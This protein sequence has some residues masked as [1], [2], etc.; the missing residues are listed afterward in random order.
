MR[1]IHHS[2]IEASNLLITRATHVCTV[3]VWKHAIAIAASDWRSHSGVR[4]IWVALHRLLDLLLHAWM[5]VLVRVHLQE[6][7]QCIV[8]SFVNNHIRVI[9]SSVYILRTYRIVPP[10]RR[11]AWWTL[12]SLI[13]EANSLFG[14]CL[15]DTILLNTALITHYLFACASICFH[16]VWLLR[17]LSLPFLYRFGCIFIPLFNTCLI[18]KVGTD[19]F[20]EVFLKSINYLIPR[21]ATLVLLLQKEML[22]FLERFFFLITSSSWFLRWLTWS[23]WWSAPDWFHHGFVFEHF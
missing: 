1:V 23:W 13:L 2:T 18:K 9:W 4:V 21:I 14:L 5:V 12:L 7:L 19:I 22:H 16:L 17:Y 10:L 15:N 6:M 8:S 3:H 20:I 11:W